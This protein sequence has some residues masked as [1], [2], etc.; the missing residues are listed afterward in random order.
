VVELRQCEAAAGPSYLVVVETA[1]L[2]PEAEL[3]QWHF[4]FVR[5]SQF[6]RRTVGLA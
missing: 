2:T 4:Y 6:L 3:E 5:R 1:A